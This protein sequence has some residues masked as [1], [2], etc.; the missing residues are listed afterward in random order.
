ML[1]SV[2]PRLTT[3]SAVRV[4]PCVS[5]PKFPFLSLIRICVIVI[6]VH[7]YKPGLPWW[8][9]GKRICLPGFDPWVGKIP[10]RRIWQPTPAFFA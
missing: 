9:R 5:I 7:S 2:L 1:P 4:F 6:R 8:L 10:W 3:D